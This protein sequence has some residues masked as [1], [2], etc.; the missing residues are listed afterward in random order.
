MSLPRAA[1]AVG[2][3]ARTLWSEA[4][5]GRLRITRLPGRRRAL[6][7]IEDLRL[8]LDGKSVPAA[9]GVPHDK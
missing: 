4:A 8:W 2:V 1:E 5:C 9:E 6:I 7:K 3:S